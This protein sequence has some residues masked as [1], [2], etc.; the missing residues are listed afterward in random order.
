MFL[1]ARVTKLLESRA[2]PYPHPV[3]AREG[4]R[5]DRRAPWPNRSRTCCI[6]DW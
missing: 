1:I 2:R 6:P 3:M 4:T 5:K